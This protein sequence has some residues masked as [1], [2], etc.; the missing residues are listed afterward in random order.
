ML[1]LFLLLGILAFGIIILKAIFGGIGGLFMCTY[2]MAKG[3]TAT[4]QWLARRYKE[5]QERKARERESD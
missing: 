2:D 1:E 4:G 5:N 3:T